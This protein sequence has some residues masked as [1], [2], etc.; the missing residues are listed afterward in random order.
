MGSGGWGIMGM[1][2]YSGFMGAVLGQ[3]EMVGSD[4]TWSIMGWG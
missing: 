2:P 1:G 3:N 4:G